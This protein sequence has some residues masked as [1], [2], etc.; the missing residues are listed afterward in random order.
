MLFEYRI[1]SKECR[2]VKFFSF[3]IQY[4]LFD[5]RYFLEPELSDFQELAPIPGGRKARPCNTPLKLSGRGEVYPR[6]HRR[7]HFSNLRI[8]IAQLRWKLIQ[9][10]G[11]L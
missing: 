4:S 1:S 2:I 10:F 3:D 9:R 7:R 11:I 8:G 6:P 5:I